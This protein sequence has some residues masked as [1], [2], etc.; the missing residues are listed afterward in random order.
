MDDV[1][2]KDYHSLEKAD[3]NQKLTRLQDTYFLGELFNMEFHLIRIDLCACP[4]N[5]PISWK[6]VNKN[7]KLC[8]NQAKFLLKFEKLL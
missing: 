6:N 8:R 7:A 1:I 4:Q 2:I 5:E 3:F